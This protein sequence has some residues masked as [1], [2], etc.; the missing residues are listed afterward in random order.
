MSAKLSGMSCFIY[1]VAEQL[2]D[3]S[4]GYL[5]V[6]SATRVGAIV[7]VPA[8]LDDPH[9][10]AKALLGCAQANGIRIRWLV[11]THSDTCDSPAWR[12]LEEHCL[13]AE[14]VSIVA[15]A[16]AARYLRVGEKLC[17]GGACDVVE[18]RA[19]RSVLRFENHTFPDDL[20]LANAVA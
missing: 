2:A 8:G 6:D 14:S 4:C 1:P 16:G 20:P 11:R 12:Y 18:V 17:L 5:V 15:P 19:G 3:A 13:C 7:D 9:V 10:V